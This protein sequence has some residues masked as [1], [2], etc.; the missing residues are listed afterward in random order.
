MDYVLLI[1]GKT[2]RKMTMRKFR[3]MIYK[4]HFDKD[5]LALEQKKKTV[6]TE[7]ALA[8]KATDFE[9]ARVLSEELEVLIQSL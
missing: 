3:K 4:N 7:I 5:D 1:E 6:E 9:Q 8:L 2:I